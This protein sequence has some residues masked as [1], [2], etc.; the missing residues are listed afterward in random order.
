MMGV[1]WLAGLV[2]G[3]KTLSWTGSL[4]SGYQLI[5]G[6]VIRLPLDDY[7]SLNGATIQ[8]NDLLG[9][10]IIHKMVMKKQQDINQAMSTITCKYSYAT[11]N[12]VLLICMKTFLIKVDINFN[13]MTILGSSKTSLQATDLS[14]SN[15][16]CSDIFLEGGFAYIPCFDQSSPTTNIFLFEVPLST[17]PTTA[18]VNTCVNTIG[19]RGAVRL[20]KVSF[21][22]SNWQFAMW[23]ASITT[24]TAGTM[25]FVT[26]KMS[27][28]GTNTQ[29]MFAGT[30]NLCTLIGNSTMQGVI[31]HIQ[32]LQ[33]TDLLY[34]V[35]LE[36]TGFKGIMLGVLSVEQN[37][38]VLTN[39]TNYNYTYYSTQA[40]T[41]SQPHLMSFVSPALNSLVAV[42]KTNLYS[43]TISNV[44]TSTPSTIKIMS[45]WTTAFDCGLLS[46]AGV[47]IGKVSNIGGALEDF[48]TRLSVEYRYKSGNELKEVAIHYNNTK[49]GCSRSPGYTDGFMQTFNVLGPYTAVSSKEDK[50]TFYR[51]NPDLQ[52]NV[53][54]NTTSTTPQNTSIQITALM[55]GY[56]SSSITFTY[57]AVSEASNYAQTTL[58]V[59]LVKS[60]S[61]TKFILPTSPINFQINSP[62]F[63]TN[64][65]NISVVYSSNKLVSDVTNLTNG[66]TIYKLLSVDVDTFI[67]VQRKAG[68][69]EAYSIFYT[70]DVG[71]K[72]AIIG[73]T[74]APIVLA[75]DGLYVFKAAKVANH[76]CIFLKGGFTTQPKLQVTC[77]V[78]GI[79]G[80]SSLTIT[81]M[82]LSNTIEVNDMQFYETPSKLEVLIVATDISSGNAIQT[83]LYYS[84][85]IVNN[86]PTF[87][88]SP[89][90][91]NYATQLLPGYRITD[92]SFDFWGDA[93][94]A[95]CN[96]KG[97]PG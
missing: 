69:P 53:P 27:P 95:V 46:S 41:D 59:P 36:D 63:T 68:F 37:V 79:G 35:S 21:G 25:N 86:I 11:Q 47:Y 4:P 1:F 32:G 84:F 82:G 31:K 54:I 81:N 61:D 97:T 3:Q 52:L 70:K 94:G 56:T 34:A 91:L 45:N 74:D 51:T 20:A 42:D 26:C 19:L 83:L 78:D 62:V 60:Y 7:L 73:N 89:V 9:R 72:M 44:K 93:E 66:Y 80:G 8:T 92:V 23:D 16:E 58:S 30:Y 96:E 77:S 17:M 90:T 57:A 64:S 65:T 38:G 5:N 22:A 48:S 88:A 28:T 85:T 76:A 40:L 55:E 18:R 29:S 24:P 2:L 15:Q 6:D 13:A 67:A 14:Q 71:Q 75:S 10:Q 49:Y 33:N 43:W 87:T 50:L 12:Y 39:N